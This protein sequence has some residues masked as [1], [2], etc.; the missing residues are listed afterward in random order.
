MS[1]LHFVFLLFLIGIDPGDEG[2]RLGLR[3]LLSIVQLFL[4]GFH[5]STHFDLV[6]MYHGFEPSYGGYQTFEIRH[7]DQSPGFNSDGAQFAAQSNRSGQSH[8]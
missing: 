1:S 2:S 3:F 8:V 5:L 4:N 7:T 6:V